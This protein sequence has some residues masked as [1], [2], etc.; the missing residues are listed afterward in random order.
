VRIR[1]SIF[2][3]PRGLGWLSPKVN[4]V[5]R[6]LW[7]IR[8]FNGL[9][10]MVLEHYIPVFPLS[11]FVSSFTY[12]KDFRADHALDRL[13]PDGNV[14]LLIE[15]TG[16]PQHVH[17]NV[18]HAIIQTCR[19]VWFSG[20]RDTYITIPS[21]TEAEMFVVNFQKGMS[22]PFLKDPVHAYKNHVVDGTIAISK[23]LPDL[24]DQLLEAPGVMEKFAL[25]EQYLYRKLDNRFEINPCIQ[26]AVSQMVETPGTQMLSAIVD[27]VGYSQK[28]FIRMF[29]D[30]VGLTPKSFMRITRFQKAIAD[31]EKQEEF[32]WIEIA[33]EC[34]YYDHAHFVHD[35]KSFA[36]M[37]PQVYLGRRSTELN[38][39]P[40]G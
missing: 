6:A 8:I 20:N 21:G 7:D 36:G 34:G 29:K 37:T 11:Q 5:S 2:A 32:K 35:F 25:A 40:I 17:D 9:S 31:V 16:T 3:V 22:G 14:T 12:F 33:F 18:T 10:S 15:L 26:Y 28:H 38:Y 30:H 24:R 23:D 27:K 1:F 13:L 39:I 4:N 19:D